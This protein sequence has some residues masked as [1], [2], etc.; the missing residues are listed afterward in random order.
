MKSQNCKH[1]LVKTNLKGVEIDECSKCRGI[2]FDRGELTKAKDSTDE[3]LR[4]LDFDVFDKKNKKGA[5]SKVHCPSCGSEMTT[6]E[7]INSKVKVDRCDSCH[8]VWLDAGEFKKIIL[9]L[10]NIIVTEK[11]SDYAKDA[12]NELK[13]ILAGPESAISEIK[14]F[15]AVLNFLELRIQAEHPKF[16]KTITT[17]LRAWPIR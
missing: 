6:L 14:D 12:A 8:G 10:E 2:W 13:E 9:Y 1:N 17:L 16:S 5:K 7:Y 4:F 3:D 11:A 15:L